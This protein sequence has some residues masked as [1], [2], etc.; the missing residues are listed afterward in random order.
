MHSCD[1]ALCSALWGSSS[2]AF[3]Y[4]PSVGASR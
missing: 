3:S 4:R 2:I 1:V